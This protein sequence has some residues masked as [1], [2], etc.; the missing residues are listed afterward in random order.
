MTLSLTVLRVSTSHRH[1]DFFGRE[2]LGGY[3]RLKHK[4]CPDCEADEGKADAGG[5]KVC[6]TCGGY[7]DV[8]K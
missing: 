7:G 3:D 5:G 1:R 2:R 4:L 8:P 6:G